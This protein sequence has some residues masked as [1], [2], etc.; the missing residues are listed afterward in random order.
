MERKPAT[1]PITAVPC[2][3]DRHG[4]P[5]RRRRYVVDDRRES[6]S[7]GRTR[8]F[9]HRPDLDV[10]DGTPR[11]TPVIVHTDSILDYREPHPTEHD[12]TAAVEVVREFHRRLE[13]TGSRDDAAPGTRGTVPPP[14]EPSA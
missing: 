9:E 5:L 1:M 13:S 3:R 6:W 7:D 2:G 4:D 12:V 11:F 8:V 10:S 14:A